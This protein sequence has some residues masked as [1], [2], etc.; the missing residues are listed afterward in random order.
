MRNL[1]VWWR[2]NF[3]AERQPLLLRSAHPAAPNWS[4]LKNL[5]ERAA[6]YRLQEKPFPKSIDELLEEGRNAGERPETIPKSKQ[7]A[8]CTREGSHETEISF[9]VANVLGTSSFAQESGAFN[10]VNVD[11]VLHN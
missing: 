7:F 2:R 1:W 9:G 5:R 11:S 6:Q 3:N 10:L 4:W 8:D